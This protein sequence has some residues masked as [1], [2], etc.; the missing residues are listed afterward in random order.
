MK[1]VSP[2][3]YK[4]QHIY[5]SWAEIELSVAQNLR[6]RSLLKL[7]Q[8]IGRMDSSCTSF[9]DISSKK[10]GQLSLKKQIFQRLQPR[11]LVSLR[12]KMA[13]QITSAFF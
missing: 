3:V 5:V 10:N 4:E 2:Y 13:T 9:P 11:T 6:L 8:V 7:K 1:F 12:G